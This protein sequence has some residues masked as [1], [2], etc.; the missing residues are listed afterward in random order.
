LR[1]AEVLGIKNPQ[2]NLA[3]VLERALDLTLEK[4]DPQQKLERRREREQKRREAG[5]TG[6][7]SAQAGNG[8]FPRAHEEATKERP[9]EVPAPKKRSRW[10][11]S[12]VRELVLER[13]G[14]QCQFRGPDGTRCIQR[15][16]LQVD[17]IQAFSKEGKSEASNLQILCK[18]HNLFRAKEEFGAELIRQRI[19]EKG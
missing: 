5:S 17:H 9:A 14:Y 18:A 13:G 3:E 6:A 19:S 8:A 11:P 4:K 16:Q 7:G 12:A 10:I 1:A 15:T 2:R